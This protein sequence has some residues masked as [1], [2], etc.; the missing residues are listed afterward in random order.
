MK[1]AA[2][3]GGVRFVW[4]CLLLPV[5]QAQAGA[6]AA[7]EP[8]AP[9]F[10]AIR[11]A[12]QARAQ[13]FQALA[14]NTDA[15]A[16]KHYPVTLNRHPIRLDDGCYDAFRFTCPQQ[17]GR[18]YW[19]FVMPKGRWEWSIIP[20]KGR[21]AGFDDYFY[22]QLPAD[23]AG[24]GKTDDRVIFQSLPVAAR[25]ASKRIKVLLCYELGEQRV[26]HSNV[27]QAELI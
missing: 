26:V 24:L 22:E 18:F 6:G 12:L 23:I 17:G 2:V 3:T 21:M 20:A 27:V 16:V 14:P 11:E 5:A 9:R 15:K 1:I 10:R 4:V 7:L 25:V 13:Q 19:S 8:E